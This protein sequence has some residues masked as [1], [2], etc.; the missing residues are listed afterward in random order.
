MEIQRTLAL[1]IT[2]GAVTIMY[3]TSAKPNFLPPVFHL[4]RNERIF[5]RSTKLEHR[6]I[7]SLPCAIPQ[8]FVHPETLTDIQWL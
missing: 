4:N 5:S 1:T 8:L 6:L 3:S 2:E 7:F